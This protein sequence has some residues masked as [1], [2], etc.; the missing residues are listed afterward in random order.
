MV[1]FNIS[2]TSVVYSYIH[3]EDDVNIDIHNDHLLMDRI[4]DINNLPLIIFGFY[5]QE[6]SK[7][8]YTSLF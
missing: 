1:D 2:N 3:N 8:A 4:N 6:T 7:N 5:S